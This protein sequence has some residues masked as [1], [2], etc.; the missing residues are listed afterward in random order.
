[1][2]HKVSHPIGSFGYHMDGITLPLTWETDWAAL[3]TKILL[4]ELHR[5][6][7]VQSDHQKH[8]AEEVVVNACGDP[9]GCGCGSMTMEDL[10]ESIDTL[11]GELATREHVPNKQERKKARQ[12]RAKT[13]RTRDRRRR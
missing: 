12:E 7:A 6:R 5:L 10:Q 2:S 9:Y 3:D 11:K 4:Q 13:Q 1:V 8:G